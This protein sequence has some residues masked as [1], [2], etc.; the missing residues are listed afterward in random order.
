MAIQK[1]MGIAMYLKQ[2][3][4]MQILPEVLPDYTGAPRLGK[5][6]EGA[7]SAF[8]RPGP[9]VRCPLRFSGPAWQFPF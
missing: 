9:G 1:Y 6:A 8:R 4:E 5:P 3:E 7:S 2:D